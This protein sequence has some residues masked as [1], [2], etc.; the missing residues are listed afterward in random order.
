[1]KIDKR[2]IISGFIAIFLLYGGYILRL[3]IDGYT[4]FIFN[5]PYNL[6]T[7]VDGSCLFFTEF[8]EILGSK[9]ISI[10]ILSI[11]SGFASILVF[12]KYLCG[13]VCPFG[14]IQ[15]LLYKLRSLSPVGNLR[16]PPKYRKIFM[17]VRYSLL[18]LFLVGFGFCSICP[19]RYIIP[20]LAGYQTEIELGFFIGVFIIGISLVNERFFC[21]I[22]PMGTF[23]GLFNFISPHKLKKDCSAC[24]ECAICYEVCPMDIK[25]IYSERETSDVFMSDCILCGK[26]VNACP[27]DNA[28]QIQFLKKT[29][30]KSSR[31][32]YYKNN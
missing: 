23:I 24:T 31:K 13:Y 11:I 10:V 32:K 17:I 20:P 15:D 12:G 9:T 27:E 3:R 26:C 16:L 6:S 29:V 8:F 19:V 7:V 14:F 18:L 25:E 21:K 5:C 4:L 28:L 30:S 22:C 2:F 1:M